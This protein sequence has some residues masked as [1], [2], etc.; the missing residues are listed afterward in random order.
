[1]EH[2]SNAT[3]STSSASTVVTSSAYSAEDELVE[4][5]WEKNL[6][7][8]KLNV[9]SSSVMRYCEMIMT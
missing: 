4:K 9:V 5:Y 2:R 1:M 8:K 6:A 7:D 3:P